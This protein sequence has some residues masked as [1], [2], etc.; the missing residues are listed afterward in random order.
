MK[1][2]TYPQKKWVLT[3][4]LL[5]ALGFN[6]SFNTNTYKEYSADYASSETITKEVDTPEGTI[7]VMYVPAGEGK[8][9]ALIPKKK[10]EGGFC[11]DQSCGLDAVILNVDDQKNVSKLNVALLKA[12]AEEKKAEAKEGRK[13]KPE[14]KVSSRSKIRNEDAEDSEEVKSAKEIAR[15]KTEEKL[16]KIADR[17]AKKGDDLEKLEYLSEEIVS[18]MEKNDKKEVPEK[19]VREFVKEHVLD[20]FKSLSDQYSSFV[21]LQAKSRYD[22]NARQELWDSELKISDVREQQTKALMAIEN[23]LE[24]APKKYEDVRRLL[25]NAEAI[26]IRDEAVLVQDLHRR[27]TQQTNLVEKNLLQA[28]AQ[29]RTETLQQM[30]GAFKNI[31]KSAFQ[32]AVRA[33]L[34]TSSNRTAYESSYAN[35][36]TPIVDGIIMNPVNYQ[37]PGAGVSEGLF[38]PT[39]TVEPTLT[40]RLQNPGRGVLPLGTQPLAPT[41]VQ[42]LSSSRVVSTLPQQVTVPTTGQTQMIVTQDGQ[43]TFGQVVPA[44]AEALRMRQQLRG[45]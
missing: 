4:A 43:I 30:N 40:P 23:I 37:I 14:E 11:L 27:A 22:L 28:E 45:Q 41:T 33:K 26:L 17:A 2:F 35:T 8:V 31:N 32:S 9:R 15:E 3:G 42:T 7:P 20:L 44:T 29:S 10:T 1:T 21:S 25:V 6:A 13:E 39:G 19:L 34:M 18:F 24:K 5:A 16:E 36:T 38:Q 12:L